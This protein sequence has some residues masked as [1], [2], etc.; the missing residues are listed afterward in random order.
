MIRR[1][2]IP[3]LI[4]ALFVLAAYKMGFKNLFI[5]SAVRT[6]KQES[7]LDNLTREA[8]KAEKQALEDPSKS[9]RAGEAWENLGDRHLKLK[10]WT[11]AIDSFKKA[12]EYGN[13]GAPVHFG[14]ALGYANRGRETDSD[15]DID[16]AIRHYRRAL[17]INPGMKDAAYGLALVLYYEKDQKKRAMEIVGKI[18]ESDPTYYRARFALG[19]MRYESGNL[20]GALTVYENLYEDLK[21]RPDSPRIQEF[22]EKA[23]DNITRIMSE[24]NRQ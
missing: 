7:N 13:S 3:L 12:I 19:R 11:P 23:S 24:L 6:V 21:K 14:L 22:K 5:P 15:P 1:F 2:I 9:N 4:L 8:K 16:K 17:E 18:I 20:P 10:N